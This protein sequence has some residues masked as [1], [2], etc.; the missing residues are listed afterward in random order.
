[1]NLGLTDLVGAI[2]GFVLTLMVVSYVI[3]DNA[4]FRLAVHIFIGVAAGYATVL[5]IYN[6]LWYQLLVPLLNN[7]LKQLSL[8]A[9][10]LLLGI[11]LLTKA[12]PRL[13]RVGSPVVAFLVGVGAAT[14]ISGAISGTLFPQVGATINLFDLGATG[15]SGSKLLGWVVNALLILIGT[16]TSLAY[17]HFGVRSR[18]DQTAQRPLWI[19]ILS[20]I[21]QV[22]I[23]VA[24]G[25]LFAGAYAAALAALVE[26]ISFVW[27]FLSDLLSSLL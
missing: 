9:P 18:G 5:V 10:P 13:S 22:F 21:G 6:V 3:K 24:L 2:L 23:A 17:F 1:M 27:K 7:P 15:L 12:S 16:I 19:E 26:R 4:L 25:T 14:A 11:W 8:V 20:Q